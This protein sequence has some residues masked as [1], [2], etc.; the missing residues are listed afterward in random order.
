M[1]AD[2]RSLNPRAFGGIADVNRQLVRSRLPRRRRL[3]QP[4]HLFEQLL[5]LAVRIG[6]AVPAAALGAHFL[7][8]TGAIPISFGTN[9]LDE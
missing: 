4:T 2:R 8:T 6:S 3:D 5:E 7:E 9:W 1:V